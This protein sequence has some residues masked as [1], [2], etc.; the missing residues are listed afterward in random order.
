M[1][2][3]NDHDAALARVDALEAELARVRQAQAVVKPAVPRAH[4]YRRRLGL[5][6]AISITAGTAVAIAM[7]A[8][9]PAPTESRVATLDTRVSRTTL[10]AC[11]ADIHPAPTVANDRLTPAQAATVQFTGAPCRSDL[12]DMIA[13]GLWSPREH[14]TLVIWRDAEDKLA[15][16]I[17]MVSTY[18]QSSPATLDGYASSPQLWREYQRAL[19]ERDKALAMWQ[20]LR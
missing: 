10:D 11:I 14:D 4:R 16:T 15:N 12:G 20:R 18:Y 6:S 7:A 9:S 1:S 19:G 2:Y 5:A 8:T 17:A 3:R 13:E